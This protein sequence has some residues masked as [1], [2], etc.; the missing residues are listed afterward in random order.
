MENEF[1]SL[2]ID[3]TKRNY[4]SE[5]EKSAVIYNYLF[6]DKN[7]RWMDR[8]IFDLDESNRDSYSLSILHEVGLNSG[9]KGIFKNYKS[10]EDAILV[11]DKIK[12]SEKIIEL[13][14]EYLS[15]QSIN[16]YELGGNTNVLQESEDINGNTDDTETFF[17]DKSIKSLVGLSFKEITSLLKI[18]SVIK[19]NKNTISSLVNNIINLGYFDENSI[20]EKYSPKKIS[21]KS[22]RLAQNG[23]PKESM[24]LEGI[25]F[26]KVSKEN[27]GDSFIYNKFKNTVFV[28]F[29][30]QYGNDNKNM[31]DIIFKGTKIWCM[32]EELLNRDIKMFWEKINRI[33]NNGIKITEK[34]MGNK[35]VKSNDL[36][37]LSDNDYIHVR[38]KATNAADTVKLPNGEYITKQGY[39]LNAKFIGKIVQVL[40]NDGLVGTTQVEVERTTEAP[41]IFH[42]DELGELRKAM[43]KKVYTIDI[44]VLEIKRFNHEFS[45]VMLSQQI[46]S[47]L[48]YR[49]ELNLIVSN[50]VVDLNEFMRNS[51]LSE[52]YFS[53]VGNTL[54]QTALFRRKLN[55]MQRDYELFAMEPGL[56]ITIQGLEKAGISIGEIINFQQSIIRYITDEKFYTMNMLRKS[57]YYNILFEYGFEDIF[58]EEL[59]NVNAELNSYD[60]GGNY[61]FSI[62][63]Q[64]IN[65]DTII[66]SIIFGEETVSFEDL[67]DRINDTYKVNINEPKL[68]KIL[69]KSKYYYSDELDRIFPNKESFYEYVYEK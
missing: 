40:D 14:R 49:K 19:N 50:D 12:S 38:P 4:F 68:S 58:Y 42:R 66:G 60:I 10:I 17:K 25:N 41:A 37:G 3:E 46:L 1:P 23:T 11:L 33:I 53:D 51:I 8:N 47:Q 29:V 26:L 7:F 59:I 13:L 48:G 39:W 6:M 62:N 54:Y 45:K 67:K 34:M 20:E 35:V 5:N 44:F 43:K 31:D 2:T 15:S 69:K 18:T 24:S 22:V 16:D 30:F 56:Y 64:L 36:P 32:D 9:H 28:F 63:N 27:W 52:D 65:E 61:I 21:V 57:G 55:A